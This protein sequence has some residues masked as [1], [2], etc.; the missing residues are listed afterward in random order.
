MLCMIE[1]KLNGPNIKMNGTN[2]NQYICIIENNQIIYT[3]LE[4]VTFKFDQN[5]LKFFYKII[6][7]VMNEV[8]KIL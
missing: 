4:I 7:P 5:R 2:R 3:H 6:S 1:N 8:M